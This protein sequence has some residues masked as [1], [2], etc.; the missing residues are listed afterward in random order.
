MKLNV[1]IAIIAFQ[2]ISASKYVH[3]VVL[4]LVLLMKFPKWN[5]ASHT[6]NRL[7][8]MENHVDIISLRI[9]MASILQQ[10]RIN[11]SVRFI[12]FLIEYFD[13]FR[14]HL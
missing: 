8:I 2:N 14:I 12:Y 11:V 7:P 9:F 13:S 3:L 6:E 10:K 5:H 1:T 4:P